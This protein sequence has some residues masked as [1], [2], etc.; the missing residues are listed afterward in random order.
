MSM[1]GP[2][3][4]TSVCDKHWI[5][6]DRQNHFTACCHFAGPYWPEP[7][8]LEQTQYSWMCQ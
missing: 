5:F 3:W 2:P 8:H 4:N 6:M 7:C 1:M